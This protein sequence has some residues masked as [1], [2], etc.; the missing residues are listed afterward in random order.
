L[1]TAAVDHV[2]LGSIA[3]CIF[4]LLAS[5]CRPLAACPGE[6]STHPWLLLL[7]AAWRLLLLLLPAAGV[8][9]IDGDVYA[10]LKATGAFE[11]MGLDADEVGA[12]VGGGVLRRVAAALLYLCA[13]S[14]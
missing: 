4:N 14:G 1:T 10:E 11:Q 12:V 13:A 6:A 8:L 7:P 2:G 5:A 3:A 9:P